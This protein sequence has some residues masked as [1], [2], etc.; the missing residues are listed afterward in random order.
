MRDCDL[1]RQAAERRGADDLRGSRGSE[2]ALSLACARL[3]ALSP[4]RQASLHK[5]RAH[6]HHV[7]PIREL[8]SHRFRRVEGREHARR[9]E[10]A[11]KTPMGEQSGASSAHAGPGDAFL[12]GVIRTHQHSRGLSMPYEVLRRLTKADPGFMHTL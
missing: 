9:V 1:C 7:V 5:A 11:Q 4:S 8:D 12:C 2:G 10:P 6:T 3:Q